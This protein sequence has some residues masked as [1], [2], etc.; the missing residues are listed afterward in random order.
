F[1]DGVHAGAP[2]PVPAAAPAPPPGRPPVL[3]VPAA[4]RATTGQPS[5]VALAAADPDGGPVAL[6]VHG[7]P[8]GAAF[9]PAA[10]VVRWTP[11]AGQEGTWPLRVEATDDDGRSATATVDL[12]AR[13]P[14]HPGAYL[15]LGD[16][17]ASGYG[18]DRADYLAGDGCG[19]AEGDGYPARVAGRWAGAAS[20]D[21]VACSGATADDL[22]TDPVPGPDALV[23]DGLGDRSQ[24]DWAVAANP[25]LVT[26]TVGAND[27]R[28]FAAPELIGAGGA[29]DGERLAGRLTALSGD[30]DHVLARLVA[31]TDATVVVTTYH[32]PTAARP[33]GIAGC[34]GA[35]FAGAAGRVVEALDSTLAD[36]AGRFGDRVLLAD[37]RPAFAG[38]G[39]GNGIGPDGVR[40]GQLPSWVPGPVVHVVDGLSGVTPFCADGHP[41]GDPWVS[42]FDC[43]HPNATGATAYAAAVVAALDAG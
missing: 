8:A 11:A 1:A 17:V 43:V 42:A 18:L 29:L 6:A 24:V 37:V 39:A 33:H 14:A 38:H 21:V 20:V 30:L 5:E 35:C 9:D 19:R 2:A 7:L 22:R 26:V 34:E 10:G 16:S 36:V 31:A 4:T 32:D 12:L 40:A 13:A 27:L 41:S 23:G 3:T 28:F 25:G 15:A